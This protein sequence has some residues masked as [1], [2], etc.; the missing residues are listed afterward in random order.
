MSA[1]RPENRAEASSP[2]AG[3]LPGENR[4]IWIV[5]WTYG[6]FYFCRNNISV[7]LP[8]IE[9]E[10]GLDKLQMG[11]VLLSLKLA[12]GV[13]QFLNG[14]ISEQISPR[15]MLAIGM[16][17]S[18]A[19]NVV[20]GFG[21]GLYFFIFIWACN[22]YSQSLG[23]TPCVRVIGNWIPVL[24]RGKAIGIVGTGYQ[25]TGALTFLVSGFAVSA[26]GWRGAFWVPPVILLI[27]S[28]IMLLFLRETP[29]DHASHKSTKKKERRPPTDWNRIRK[30][31]RLT[32]SNRA[33][34]LLALSLGMLNACRY[35]FLDWGVSHLVAIERVN[36]QEP[37]IQS[38]INSG[39]LTRSET[40]RLQNIYDS[41]LLRDDTQEEVKAAIQ[42]GLIPELENRKSRSA[43][44][45]SAVK[46]AV[47]PIGAIF[48]SFLAGW[49]T[50]RFLGSRR[51][52][53]ICGLLVILGCLT[54]IYDSVARTSFEGTMLIL[55][56]IGFCI[57]G[58]QVLLVGT[59]PADLAHEGTS[60]A[61]AG[62]VNCGGYFGAA[63]AGD[64]MT[65]YL[66]KH[67]GW[68]IAI[69]GWAGW[70]FA[71]AITVAFL[72]NATGHKKPDDASPSSKESLDE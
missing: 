43:V 1:D 15:R 59:A 12:Y 64:L 70:A 41:D 2:L 8:G 42:D 34:W 56:L 20:F 10:L 66:A 62:F 23:W 29:D 22:G 16:I 30:N 28:V 9:D 65:G 46:Y 26:F 44:L 3:P 53:V 47:L 35:G 7:A 60:A 5:W 19:L 21:T 27:S 61:A 54:L 52:P 24:R 18:A 68:E 69:Y 17:G 38:A 33:L 57:Y 31:L 13:G 45:K 48:G 14:Q 67:Y 51:A 63:F 4:V 49:A 40:L 37:A 72:W 11:V 36:E 32:F 39:Q 50:D 55:G 71:A 6:A 58:P 25:L